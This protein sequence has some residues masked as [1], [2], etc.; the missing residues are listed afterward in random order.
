MSVYMHASACMCV[1]TCRHVCERV[2]VCFVDLIWPVTMSIYMYPSVYVFFWLHVT[3]RE[4]PISFIFSCPQVPIMN[5]HINLSPVPHS[6][7]SVPVARIGSASLWAS[8]TCC[9]MHMICMQKR[10]NAL[11]A[12]SSAES[13]CCAWPLWKNLHPCPGSGGFWCSLSSFSWSIR[14][15]LWTKCFRFLSENG[16]S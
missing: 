11:P 12:G 10:R 4:A 7:D 13:D 16:L 15:W 3:S 14:R 8:N 5:T 6:F 1:C 2:Y 9:C